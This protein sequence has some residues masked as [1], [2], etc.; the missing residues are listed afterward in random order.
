M[1]AML[2]SLLVNLDDYPDPIE[3]IDIDSYYAAS[4]QVGYLFSCTKNMKA[5]LLH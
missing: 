3:D 5:H 2:Q 1:Y 4:G